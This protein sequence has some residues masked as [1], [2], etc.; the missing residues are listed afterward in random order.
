MIGSS[1]ETVQAAEQICL[2]TMVALA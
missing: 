2:Q 1:D